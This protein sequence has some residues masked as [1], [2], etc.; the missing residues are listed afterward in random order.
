[1]AQNG[2]MTQFTECFPSKHEAEVP[3]LG[4]CKT[5]CGGVHL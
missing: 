5:G 4:P 2:G 1:M 3:S